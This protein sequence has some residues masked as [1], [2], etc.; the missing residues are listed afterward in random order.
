MKHLKSYLMLGACAMA[1]FMS[2]CSQEKTATTTLSGLDP[3]KFFFF[4][5]C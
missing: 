5:Y 2:S 3:E 4:I 1:M